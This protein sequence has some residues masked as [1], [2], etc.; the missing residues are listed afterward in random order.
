MQAL[1]RRRIEAEEDNK[2]AAVNAGEDLM[3]AKENAVIGPVSLGKIGTTTAAGME[4]VA[5]TTALGVED[6]GRATVAGLGIMTMAAA[7][8]LQGAGPT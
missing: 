3:A 1:S 5:V 7:G 8:I 2:G 6:L 4:D